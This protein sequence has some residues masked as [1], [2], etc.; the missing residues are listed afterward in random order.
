MSRRRAPGASVRL[1]DRAGGGGAG[2]GARVGRR[3]AFAAVLVAAVLV[4]ALLAWP[5][6]DAG[7]PGARTV[8]VVF[9]S[10]R[11]VSPGSAVKVAGARVGQVTAVV[12]TD[13]HRALVTLEIDRAIGPLRR[14]ARCSIR[15]EGLIGERFV[16]CEPGRRAAGLLAEGPAGRQR[17]PV[18]ATSR[19]LDLADLLN[20]WS[21]PTGERARVL[22]NQLGLGLA[23]RGDDLRAIVE[24][25]HPTLRETRRL[26]AVVD[27]QRADLRRTV[28]RTSRVA[29]TLADRRADLGRLTRDGALLAT[30]V[31]RHDDDLRASL[32]RL[33]ALLTEAR[34]ALSELD[35][36]GAQAE[37][38]LAAAERSAPGITRLA[39][40]AGPVVRRAE[41]T[42]DEV[43]PSLRR[44][45]TAVRRL[46]PL[47]PAVASTLGEAEPAIRES[48]RA[49]T[50]LRDAGFFEGFWSFLYYAASALSRYDANGHLFGG[51]I[52]LNRCSVVASAPTEGCSAWLRDEAAAKRGDLK[53]R[54]AVG[55]PAPA[56]PGGGR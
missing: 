5:R 37:P 36:L 28:E 35:A 10:A 44:T 21:L 12:L 23:A 1:G 24:R 3:I 50:A 33:P 32:R 6:G 31:G 40:G 30:R 13:R 42:L 51:L 20:L 4:V 16:A 43:A 14:D 53:A 2:P 46:A 54:R 48:D 29:A 47:L 22:L 39:A 38:L 9:D 15:P 8:E 19:V 34:P 41:R 11:G 27:G 55:G 25:A 17:V 7:D 18:T 45:T 49:L 52:M 56:V 26:L